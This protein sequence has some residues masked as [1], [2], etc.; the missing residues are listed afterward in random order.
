[1]CHVRQRP[2]AVAG[3]PG[4]DPCR[5]F[6]IN[7]VIAILRDFDQWCDRYFARF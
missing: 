4:I 3:Q 7:V 1:V 5:K 2:A 6:W